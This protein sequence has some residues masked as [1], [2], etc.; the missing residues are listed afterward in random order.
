[1]KLCKRSFVCEKNLSR[2]PLLITCV[3]QRLKQ[4]LCCRYHLAWNNRPIPKTHIMQFTCVLCLNSARNRVED[5]QIYLM[6]LDIFHNSFIR[7]V[8]C[9]YQ[10]WVYYAR[11]TVKWPWKSFGCVADELHFKRT[12]LLSKYSVM[13]KSNLFLFTVNIIK[14]LVDAVSHLTLTNELGM[15]WKLFRRLKQFVKWITWTWSIT[16]P[17]NSWNYVVSL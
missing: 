9:S 14:T 6:L 4:K 12:S 13:E 16:A 17:W 1:M 10:I 8:K 2:C 5:R 15:S 11:P 7:F 3:G